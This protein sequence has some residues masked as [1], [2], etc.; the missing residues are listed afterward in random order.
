MSKTI[1]FKNANCVF[2]LEQKKGDLILEGDKIKDFIAHGKAHSYTGEVHDIDGL[3]VMPGI[4]DSQVHFREPGLTHKEDLETGS[5][6]AI[7]GGICTFLEMPNTKPAT[8][9]AKAI[10][11]KVQRASQKSWANFGFFMGATAHN[12][13]ELMAAHT[14]PGVCGIKI[15]LGSSTGDL[16]L[17]EAEKLKAIF[18]HAKCAIS[19]HS[20]D[21]ERLKERMPIRDQ[22]T[23]VLEH[24]I[25]RDAQ[26]A[27]LSTVRVVDLARAAKKRVHILHITTKE[28]LDFLAANKDIASIE[29]TPQHL[30]LHSPDC[31]ERLGTYAQMNPPIRELHH[32]QAI[33][34][35]LKEGLVDIVA[36]DHAPHTKEE[37]DKGY[38]NTPSG[39][40]GVQTILPLMLN[41]VNNGQI[42]IER[43]AQLMSLNVAKRFGLKNKG[44]IAAGMDADLTIVDMNE[45]WTIKN[46]DQKSRCGYTPFNG[47]KLKG[48]PI[49]TIVQ[50]KMAMRE[51]KIFDRAG[52]SVQLD[53]AA[54]PL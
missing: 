46:E 9:S 30:Y 27:Y 33:V 16:L 47:L 11:D 31:Y 26:S 23:S 15:F 8:D 50:G 29:I 40:P 32:Q 43:L 44:K 17:Y 22:A 51:G 49:M 24:P 18:A 34:K 36:S 35:A 54:L 25:W 39:L 6:A 38:P 53:P 20:E 4:I 1:I 42:T 45:E 28:E 2:E 10:A 7:A 13:S 19:I 21:E 52:R 3:T 12:L 14:V 5:L 37:K 48:R 41:L